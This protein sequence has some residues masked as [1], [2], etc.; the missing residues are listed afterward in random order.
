MPGGKFRGRP[1]VI[2]S[3][4]NSTGRHPLTGFSLLLL[5]QGIAPGMEFVDLA[6]DAWRRVLSIPPFSDVLA[7]EPAKKT[8]S[9]YADQGSGD[10][11]LEQFG[12]HLEI[13]EA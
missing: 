8:I 11:G 7:L 1:V 2:F 13:I 3:L 5:G 9:V 12:A 6:K 10:L 4:T